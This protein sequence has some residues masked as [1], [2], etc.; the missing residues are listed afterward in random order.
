MSLDRDELVM[1]YDRPGRVRVTGDGTYEGTTVEVRGSDGKWH[2]VLCTEIHVEVRASKTAHEP[3]AVLTCWLPSLHIDTPRT[4]VPTRPLPSWSDV[5][6]A[7]RKPTNSMHITFHG[8]PDDF[9]AF[10][11]KVRN[12]F[13]DMHATVS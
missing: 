12:F 13:R 7:S 3:V 9:E 6:D 10:E 8:K 11:A 2:N 5:L 4:R 1:E